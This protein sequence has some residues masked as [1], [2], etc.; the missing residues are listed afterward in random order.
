M[1]GSEVQWMIFTDKYISFRIC[2]YLSKFEA[3]QIQRCWLF[4]RSTRVYP[5]VT[6]L[7]AWSDN[8][9]W[10]SSVPTRCSYIAILWV[11]LVS[12]AVITRCVV[13][14]RVF[15]IVV[16]FIIDSVRKLLDIPPYVYNLSFHATNM[17][18]RS[19]K[20]VKVNLSLCLTKHHAMKT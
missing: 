20:Y 15:I 4:F 12:F 16:Y 5:K 8:C 18:S 19:R 9:K 13:S 3:L 17:S 11:S 6:G 14:Q 2:V 10:Y 7:A 1:F